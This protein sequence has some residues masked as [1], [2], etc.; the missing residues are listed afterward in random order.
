MQAA[1][2]RSAELPGSSSGH[3]TA[4]K[5]GRALV[6]LPIALGANLAALVL[7]FS[8]ARAVYYPLWAV[9]AS[10]GALDRSWGGPSAA[11]ATLVHWLVAA[12]TVVAMYGVILLMERLSV[13][14]R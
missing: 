3:S 1:A 5:V 2:G 8:L 10:R 4:S 13:E 6:G 7:L 14:H 11:G 12:V 9:Q